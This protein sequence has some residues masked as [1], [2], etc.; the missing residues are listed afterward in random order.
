ML[1][2]FLSMFY[3]IKN[4]PII[5]E[6]IQKADEQYYQQCIEIGNLNKEISKLKKQLDDQTR[7]KNYYSKRCRKLHSKNK[8]LGEQLQHG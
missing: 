8:Q 2:K 3:W 5:E 7:L 6:E 1:N 4:K